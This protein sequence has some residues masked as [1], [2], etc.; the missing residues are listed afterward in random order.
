MS[1]VLAKMAALASKF[2]DPANFGSD[3]VYQPATGVA[4]ALNASFAREFQ[5]SDPTNID[6]TNSGPAA[7]V[8]AVDVPTVGPDAILVVENEV[9]QVSEVQKGPAGLHLLLLT[10]TTRNVLIDQYGDLVVS[11]DGRLIFV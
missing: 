1:N 2:V 9:F 10:E 4:V 3:A 11:Q 5:R 6:F 7:Y 8:R